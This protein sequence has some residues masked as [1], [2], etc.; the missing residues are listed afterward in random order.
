MSEPTDPILPAEPTGQSEPEADATSLHS[1]F[2]GPLASASVILA[3]VLFLL[4]IALLYYRWVTI[5]QPNSVVEVQ[6]SS[7]LSGA[8]VSVTGPG[9]ATPLTTTLSK[10]DG[11]RPRFFLN[12]GSYTVTVT[13]D[14]Q[15]YYQQHFILGEHVKGR[16]TIPPPP[17]T[18]PA[19]AEDET[20]ASR[21][22][23]AAAE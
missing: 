17:A 10:D 3:A 23:G 2:R 16:I 11:F 6:G 9:L 1:V 5:P 21:R 22:L 20:T 13:W 8:E 7:A 12:S 18:L 15:T 4:A 14:G 19:A